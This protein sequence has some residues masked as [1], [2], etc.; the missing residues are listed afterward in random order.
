M[1]FQALP[2]EFIKKW[3]NG[4]CQSLREDLEQERIGGDGGDGG[5]AACGMEF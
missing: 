4:L 1:D 5:L 2:N 3:W